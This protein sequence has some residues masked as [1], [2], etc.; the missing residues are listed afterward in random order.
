M[1]YISHALVGT[2]GRH[3]DL[4]EETMK[5]IVVRTRMSTSSDDQKK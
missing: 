4:I 1:V 5:Y 3:P 2:S